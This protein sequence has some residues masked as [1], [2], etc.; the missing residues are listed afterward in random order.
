MTGDLTLKGACFLGSLLLASK[1]QDGTGVVC[2][3]TGRLAGVYTGVTETVE[4]G[5]GKK[6]SGCVRFSDGHKKWFDNL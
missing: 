4:G 3:N 6:L 1:G 5:E 2:S